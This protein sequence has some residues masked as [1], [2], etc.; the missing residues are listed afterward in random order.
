SYAHPLDGRRA[1]LAWRDL[2]A[3][4]EGLGADGP[5]WRRVFGPLVRDAEAVVA[6][7]L[8]DMRSL[9]LQLRSPRGLRGALA[10]GLRVLVE[11]TPL[12][13]LPGRVEG[14]PLR[15]L[16][17]GGEV[18]RAMVPGVAGHAI[19]ALPA[20]APAGVALMLGTLA[21]SVGWRIPVGGSQ[22]ITDALV[23]DLRGHGGEVR[24]GTRVR[25]WRELPRARAYLLDTSPQV[26]AEIWAG[27]LPPRM[28]RRLR[29]TPA[30]GGAAK[31]DFVLSGPVPWAVPEV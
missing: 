5:A 12:W 9:P 13:N 20:L 14:R 7:T 27:R 17:F 21:H 2:D 28:E 31:V 15:R 29:R 16:R 11:G 23:A 4:A 24:T 25:S 1:G 6:A 3:T 26:A 30:G 19:A 8:A 22:A 10:F 18:A